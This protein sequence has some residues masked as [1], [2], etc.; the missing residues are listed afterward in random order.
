MADPKFYPE[1]DFGGFS[2]VDGTIAFYNRVNALLQPSDI[3]LDVGCGRGS[4][5]D[6][7]RS[8]SQGLRMLKGKCKKVIGIDVDPAG[9][10]NKAVDEFY[11]I[12]SSRWP[13]E[14]NAVDLCVSDFVMEHLEK[15]KEF[16]A[17]CWRIL[18]PGGYLCLRTPNKWGYVALAAMLIPKKMHHSFLKKAQPERETR[19]VFPAFYRCN[20]IF[21][22]KAEMEKAGFAAVVY[23][24]EAEPAYFGF[25]KILYGLAKFYH[26][27]VPEILSTCLFGFGR[28]K[29]I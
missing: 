2:R 19:D 24:T 22:M 20:T 7:S 6:L 28:K 26:K 21:K 1:A 4:F 13:L 10:E 5:M 29:L 15:P 8:Y 9:F 14:D 12:Q 3:V 17:E 23:G 27:I 16:L 18:K 25:S 11:L